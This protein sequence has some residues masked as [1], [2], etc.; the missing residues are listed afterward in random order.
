MSGFDKNKDM[1]ALKAQGW[2]EVP[3]LGEYMLRPPRALLLKLEAM[4]FHVYDALE[5][6]SIA[7]LLPDISK[8]ND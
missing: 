5:L 2:T 7:N 1:E 8:A 4:N 3:E 6:Q